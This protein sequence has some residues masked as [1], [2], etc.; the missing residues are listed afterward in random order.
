M[1]GTI[2]LSIDIVRF[3]VKLSSNWTIVANQ[4]G[5][6]SV[7]SDRKEGREEEEKEAGEGNWIK[8]AIGIDSGAAGR[9]VG[10]R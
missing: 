6:K 9:T 2:Q 5:E 1:A 10:R 8:A 4:V 3:V 7:E